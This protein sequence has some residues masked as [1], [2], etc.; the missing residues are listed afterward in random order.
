MDAWKMSPQKR[1]PGLGSAA[2]CLV[3]SLGL[4]LG[5]VTLV[6]GHLQKGQQ[7]PRKGAEARTE[8]ALKGEKV[9]DTLTRLASETDS[10]GNSFPITHR[11]K[12]YTVKS[13]LD[14]K[15]QA[16]LLE[17]LG[18]SGTLKSA[19]VVL[20]PRTGRVLA[21]ASHQGRG[22]NENL[23][24]KAAFPAA[25]LF[26]IVAAAAAIE[27]AGF[28]P[29]MPVAYEGGKYTLYP[30][31]LREHVG[32]YAN[33]TSFREAFADSIN[34]VFGRLGI[35]D[36]G[37]KTIAASAERFLFNRPIPFEIPVDKSPFRMP[38]DDMELAGV[39]SGLN[40]TT[41]IS[42]LHAA[43]IASTIANNGTMMAPWSVDTILGQEGETVYRR[44][45]KRLA[46]PVSMDTAEDLRTLMQETVSSGT[47]QRTLGALASRRAFKDVEMGAKT[48]T[49]NDL[50]GQYRIDWVAAYGLPAE[51]AQAVAV[52]VVAMH[53]KGRGL[54][55]TEIG[56]R[57]M[58]YQF[59]GSDTVQAV[60]PARPKTAA[61]RPRK[62]R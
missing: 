49:I 44:T 55:A 35:Y 13:S 45:L 57:L 62:G 34:P 23:C 56:R 26:K 37:E 38:G 42:P 17:L 6:S 2:G 25:S 59:E 46:T 9:L 41:L 40:K 11:G 4:V 30:R 20:S 29:E 15:L 32:R 48:G 3:L 18:R 36:L 39:A 1:A 8:Q 16:Y 31:Q 61:H 22:G 14:P 27:H 52:A 21:M 33:R 28:T 47:C 19:A 60:P 12:R 7:E 10:L 5:I 54:K 53:D 58:Q 51:G 24:T 43:L 50:T